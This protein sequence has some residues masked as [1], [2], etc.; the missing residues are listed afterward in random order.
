MYLECRSPHRD[1]DI[2]PIADTCSDPRNPRPADTE[3]R[4][5]GREIA[6]GFVANRSD[7]EWRA[8]CTGLTISQAARLV[9]RMPP[10]VT[11]AVPE[12]STS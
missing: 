1:Q 4:K 2:E 3:G 8:A 6:I 10:A 11:R 12:S 9:R 7:D 5:R